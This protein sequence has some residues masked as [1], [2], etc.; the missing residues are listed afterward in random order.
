MYIR[1]LLNQGRERVVYNEGSCITKKRLLIDIWNNLGLIQ[2]RGRHHFT[3]PCT[4]IFA[5]ELVK[6]MFR[7][8]TDFTGFSWIW[9][10]QFYP[11]NGSQSYL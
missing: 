3:L 1:F 2:K 8:L 9:N 11:F 7:V 4:Y 6:K 10:M 5:L